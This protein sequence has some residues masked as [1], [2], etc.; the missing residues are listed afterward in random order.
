LHVN[1]G[2]PVERNW[3]PLFDEYNVP[4]VLSGHD[5]NYQRLVVNGVTYVISG[6]GS[7]VI[8]PMDNP[9]PE[10]VSFSAKSHFVL[11]TFFPDFINLEAISIDGEI[12][13][14]AEIRIVEK[15]P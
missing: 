4:L 13:D 15:A 1:D 8:Y 3:V 5:H 12:I 6:G 11:L 7:S 9:R 14:V 10:T 2:I